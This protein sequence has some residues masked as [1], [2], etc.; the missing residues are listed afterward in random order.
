MRCS[1]LVWVRVRVLESSL[2]FFLFSKGS[3]V[4]YLLILDVFSLA[5]CEIRLILCKLLFN[6]DLKLHPESI[7]WPDQNVYY[8]WN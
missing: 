5:S 3:F 6:F 4:N 2:I 1:H 8:L 7:D